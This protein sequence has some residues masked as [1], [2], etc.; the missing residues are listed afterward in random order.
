MEVILLQKV[1]HLGNLGDKVRVKGGYGRNFLVP[2]GR[3]V[4]ATADNIKAFEERR[5]ELE[6]KA[7]G[8]LGEARDRKEK[9]EQLTVSIARKAGEQGRLFGS[10][11]ASDIAEAVTAVGVSLEK[12]EVR[13]P[14]GPFH[15]VGEY[16]VQL[17]LHTDVSATLRLT[18]VAE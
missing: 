7:S 15:A 8:E 5:A 16:E 3:A 18:V 4:T 13:L 12:R 2:S 14:E 11:G 9:I 10:V 17:H 1:E 6:K